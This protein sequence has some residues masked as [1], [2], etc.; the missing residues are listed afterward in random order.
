MVFKILKNFMLGWHLKTELFEKIKSGEITST[1]QY[2]ISSI[3]PG[4]DDSKKHSIYISLLSMIHDKH[5]QGTPTSQGSLGPN[6][7]NLKVTKSGLKLYKFYSMPISKFGKPSIIE[8]CINAIIGMFASKITWF[9][10]CFI[11]LLIPQ[12]IKQQMALF[13]EY[14]KNL[15]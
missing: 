10:I 6:Y 15:F 1:A 11:I 14:I 3:R 13:F 5:I 4:T 12:N 8:V 2:Q 7:N 9:L